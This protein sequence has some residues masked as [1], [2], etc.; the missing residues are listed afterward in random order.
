[1]EADGGR[2]PHQTKRTRR[3]ALLVA[4]QSALLTTCLLAALYVCWDVQR[5]TPREEQDNVHIRLNPVSDFSGNVSVR[6]GGV[7]SSHMMSLVP[8][9]KDLIQVS[10]TGPY[11][12][13]LYLCY[14][15]RE[16]GGVEG[17]LELWVKGHKAPAS[18]FPLKTPVKVSEEVC[19]GLHG[20]AYLR[21]K[22]KL[23][24]LLKSSASFKVKNM[25][26][27]LSYLLGSRCQLF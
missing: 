11:V 18:S 27:A 1:M 26:V 4:A 3:L 2:A 9:A 6:F 23:Q 7:Y 19:T 16:Q 21:D 8:E 15:D 13:Y 25:T 14:K 22:E 5:R 20:T 24:F 12:L 10:C 17:M